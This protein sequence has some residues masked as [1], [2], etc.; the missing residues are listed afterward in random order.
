MFYHSDANANVTML[1][2]PWQYIVAKYLYDAFG[3]VLSAAGSL[4]PQNLY[5]FS[6]KEAHPN[7]GLVSYLYRY[8]D[9]HL[10][11][12]PTRDPLGEPG[13][14]MVR[15]VLPAPL[16][17]L[18]LLVPEKPNLYSFLQNRPTYDI[19]PLGLAGMSNEECLSLL[20]TIQTLCEM[21]ISGEMDPTVAAE[22]ATELKDLYDKYCNDPSGPSA[23]SPS[24][25]RVPCPIQVPLQ[26]PPHSNNNTITPPNVWPYVP[27]TI[28]AIFLIPWPGN[29]VYGGL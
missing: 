7:S 15:A 24:N 4:A 23:P 13:F 1:I 18:A 17:A 22:E 6:S 21:G 5:R 28:I 3:N 12:W 9:P 29:P 10:Q 16:R 2:N 8:Y 25:K 27:P 20:Q 26:P 11:R 19:D 14:E